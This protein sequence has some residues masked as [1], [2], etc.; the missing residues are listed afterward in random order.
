MEN[1]L[2]L[3]NRPLENTEILAIL[4][5][6]ALLILLSIW[7]DSRRRAANA[8]RFSRKHP[9]AALICLYFGGQPAYKGDLTCEEGIVCSPFLLSAV[10]HPGRE[11]GL[12]FYASPGLTTVRL[13]L[14]APKGASGGAAVSGRISF[15]AEP[16]GVY[17][18]QIWPDGRTELSL[19]KGREFHFVVEE[20][21]PAPQHEFP[22]SEPIRPE[23]LSDFYFRE[24]RRLLGSCLCL[25]LLLGYLVAIGGLPTIVLA[26]PPAL[27]IMMLMVAFTVGTRSFHQT[28]DTLPLQRQEQ[29]QLEFQQPHPICKLFMGEV[30]LLSHCLICRH[31]GRLSLILVDEIVSVRSLRYGKTYGMA[32]S[33]IL[34]TTS[35]KNFQ[36]EFW[37]G[38]Q[39]ELPKVES[40]I[41]EQNPRATVMDS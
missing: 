24:F 25:L 13:M 10:H 29:I 19:L 35:G 27:W 9:G 15:Q 17:R 26:A 20:Q 30:H 4:G 14:R 22:L 28:W 36:L 34:Q 41:M 1:F 8:K 2:A 16:N 32:K 40:W 38:G 31:G 33:L 37:A 23:I 21:K 12:A 3:W 6:I 11:K 39:V 18:A 5:G 7:R